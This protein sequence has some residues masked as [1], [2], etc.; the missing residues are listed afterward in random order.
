MKPKEHYNF[1]V[2]DSE[3]MIYKL[4]DKGFEIIVLRKLGELE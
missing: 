3:K 1:S 2:T 4:H